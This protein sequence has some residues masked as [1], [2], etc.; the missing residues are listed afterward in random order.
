MAVNFDLARAETPGTVEHTL[1][2]VVKFHENNDLATGKITSSTITKDIDGRKKIGYASTYRPGMPVPMSE[3]VA[4]QHL[5]NDVKEAHTYIT[6]N[7][8]FNAQALNNMNTQQYAALVSAFHN[9]SSDKARKAFSNSTLVNKINDAKSPEAIAKAINEELPRWSKAGGHF[10]EGVFKRRNN[11][12]AFAESNGVNFVS[13][14]T[15]HPNFKKAYAEF[16]EKH[17][18]TAKSVQKV[19]D[20][21]HGKRGAGR[22]RARQHYAD[23]PKPSDKRRADHEHSSHKGVRQANS[24]IHAVF[25]VI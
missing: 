24:G 3:S 6:Q 5:I 8:V 25:G 22:N 20:A 7:N 16:K 17:S 9:L 1:L 4:T 21:D 11:E 14:D 2:N 10:S 15:D 19:A 18:P 23:S 13:M 12:V